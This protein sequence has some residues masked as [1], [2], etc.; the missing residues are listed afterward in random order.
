MIRIQLHGK[1]M[2]IAKYF[3]IIGN[4]SRKITLLSIEIYV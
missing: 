3:T 4:N 1:L 2:K